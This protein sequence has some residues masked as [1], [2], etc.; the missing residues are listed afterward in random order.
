MV[1]VSLSDAL[2]QC[3]VSGITTP[4]G[5]NTSA[6]SCL[7]ETAGQTDC[8][9][10]P[11][12]MIAWS[13]LQ[14]YASGPSEY[15]QVCSGGCSGNDGRLRV[16]GATP[17]IGNGPLNFRGVD[18]DGKRWF[19]CGTDT[20][21]IV[22]PNSTQTFSCP[23]S[24]LT[25][26]LVVQRVYRKVGTS[27]RFTERF[28]GTMTYHPSHGHNHVDD[29]VTFSLRLAIANEPN[30]LN[31]PIV[32][33]GAKVGFCLMDYFSCPS[34]SGNGHCRT[35]HL[36]NQ[37]TVL[38]QQSQFP[39]FGLG[40]QAYNCSPV[41]QGISSGWEDV[42]SEGLDGM[43]I[44]I[45]PGTCNGSYY[46][47]AQVDPLNNFLESNENNNWTAI[48][49]TLTQQAPANSGGTCGIISDREP[50]L[51]SG[52]QVVLTCQNAG[53]TYLWSTGATTR[54][55]TV[56]QGGNYTVTVTN[57]CGTMTSA[58]YTVTVLSA[59]APVTTGAVLSAPG[60]ATL[61][62]TG[63]DLH[64][65]AQQAGGTEAGVG[66]SFVTPSL[67]QT[68]TYWC[69]ARAMQ[70]GVSAYVGKPTNTGSGGYSSNDEY[71]VFDAYKDL[72][73]N[74]VRVYTTTAGNRTFQ[75]LAEDGS[76][77]AQ[78]T[79]FVSTGNTRV[80]LNLQVPQG[81][82]LRL[83]VTNSLRSLYRNSSSSGVN[84]PYTVP[85]I[86][87]IRTSSVGVAAYPY[88]YDWEISTRDKVCA[89]ARVA[90]TATV[91]GTLALGLSVWLEG[92]YVQGSGQM[93]D[94]L[95]GQGLMPSQ[96]PYTAMGFT[97]TGGGG[98]ETI[99]PAL[100]STTGALAPVDWVLVELRNAVDPSVIVATR[101]C[102]VLRN[103]QVVS[104]A[105]GA[106]QFVGSVGPYH[107]AIRHRNHLGCMTATA[108]SLSPIVTTIDLRQAS[109]AT[110]G[111]DAR[112]TSG[113]TMV[114]W[115]GN[116]VMNNALRYT[117]ASNDR[118]PILQAI[119]GSV[120]TGILAG[121][122]TTDV[123]LDGLTKYTGASNDRDPILLNIGGSA[124]TSIR[125]EQ[126]P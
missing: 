48:P 110:W 87:T 5:T 80:T 57:P 98:G 54:S 114:L 74:S 116:V 61:T 85:N 19:I 31:W 121:Y 92:A 101:S 86:L 41:S 59:T 112:R 66:T 58:P 84:Y 62:A 25:K 119:G 52:E 106:V 111:T 51:C 108:V 18:K 67:S 8:D 60:T 64:W 21:S 75:V 96:E 113:S 17:N 103:G 78:A 88:C 90:A 109:T 122:V 125:L 94:D 95:R 65:F 99:A 68:T 10:R 28:A 115:T 20:F 70:Q 49:F 34:A 77:I 39:N 123:N 120:P 14:T 22:D 12:V 2:G 107:V 105:G 35:D 76:F 102:V 55:I 4:N 82:N 97:Q 124:P 71:L 36:Y 37:G 73:I 38:N 29:W 24:G 72:E 118:D 16:T 7:C 83:Y 69:E 9:L 3:T 100:L 33:T 45:P 26:Q 79:A 44:N 30:P 46:I 56:D 13:A 32:G 104:P 126:L 27:M 89:S 11:D 93:R 47:V 15:P 43:W 117:G 53:Y 91:N 1:T 6:T 63:T 23:N 42:Y 40:G 50:V 81:N